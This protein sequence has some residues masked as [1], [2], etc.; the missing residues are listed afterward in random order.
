MAPHSSGVPQKGEHRDV[1]TVLAIGA[2]V[3]RPEAQSMNA[4]PQNGPLARFTELGGGGGPVLLMTARF[5]RSPVRDAGYRLCRRRPDL[6]LKLSWRLF[7]CLADWAKRWQAEQEGFA[8]G[9]ILSAAGDPVV[10]R[11]VGRCLAD[12]ARLGRPLIWGT[13]GQRIRWQPRFMLTRNG[14]PPERMLPSPSDYARL[15]MACDASE[16]CPLFDPILYSAEPDFVIDNSSLGWFEER[17]FH[18]VA[19][20]GKVT[21]YFGYFGEMPDD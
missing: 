18:R 2:A 16:F 8:A 11:A 14:W 15:G 9:I 13:V 19:R 17:F 10:E 21:I 4:V 12:L 5:G 3:R 20:D 7:A 1:Y 6:D